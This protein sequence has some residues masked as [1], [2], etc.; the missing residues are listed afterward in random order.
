MSFASPTSSS[1]V[2]PLLLFVIDLRCNTER[3]YYSVLSTLLYYYFHIDNRLTW[4]WQL[5]NDGNGIIPQKIPLELN[6]QSL[7]MFFQNVSMAC[8]KSGECWVNALT[9]A[10]L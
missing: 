3:I 9:R 2:P 4:S 10:V 7:L 8:S 5:F 6:S 1:R